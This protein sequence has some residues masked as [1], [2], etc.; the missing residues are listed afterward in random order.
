MNKLAYVLISTLLFSSCAELQP[1]ID[2]YAVIQEQPLTS[3]DVS[4]GLKEALK[5]GSKNASSI[6]ST[7]D[8]FYKDELVKILLPPE[9]QTISKNIKMIPGGE[10]L[11]EKVVVRLNRAAEDA[12]SEAVPIFASAITSMSIADA[13]GILKGEDNAATMYLRNKTYDQ[14]KS[15]FLPKVNAS[16]D[17]KLVANISTNESWNLLTSN[18]N[19][20]ANSFAGK[21]ANLKVVDTELDQYVTNKALDALFIKVANE[22]KL[23]RKD[24]LKRVSEILRRVFG[25]LD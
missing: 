2:Q 15:L 18:Y 4:T 24:P 5:V 6:L 13:F 22:E 10:D 25:K 16:L 8:G 20:I 11:V 23:I 3:A 17:K 14:L 7:K 9:A 12:V 19:N 21:I 1:F